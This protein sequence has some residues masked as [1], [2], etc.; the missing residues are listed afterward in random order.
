[1]GNSL[2]WSEEREEV[3]KKTADYRQMRERESGEREKGNLRR[4][5]RRK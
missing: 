4:R 1:M 5:M 3:K 2:L